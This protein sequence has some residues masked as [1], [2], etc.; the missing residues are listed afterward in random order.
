MSLGE[1]GGGGAR[2]LKMGGAAQGG[3]DPKGF[4][5]GGLRSLVIWPRGGKRSRGGE[6]PGTPALVVFLMKLKLLTKFSS[7]CMH[8]LFYGLKVYDKYVKH[9]FFRNQC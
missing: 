1:E 4:G 8:Q 9:C 5:P 6:I 2:S 7:D 3:R